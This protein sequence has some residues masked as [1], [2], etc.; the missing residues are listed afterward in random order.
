MEWNLCCGME[1]MLRSGT[2]VMEWNLHY[3]VE[4]MS[5]S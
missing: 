5:Q 1:L 2:H 3:D 4:L